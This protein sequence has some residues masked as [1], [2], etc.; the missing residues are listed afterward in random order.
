MSDDVRYP[1]ELV[2]RLLHEQHADLADLPLTVV[3][4]GYDN[5]TVRLGVE[6]AVRLP[7]SDTPPR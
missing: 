2:R 7:R 3:D 6:L 5:Q 1:V 4:G